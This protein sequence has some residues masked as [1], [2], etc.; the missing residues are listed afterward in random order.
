MEETRARI[1]AAAR[2]LLLSDEGLA[3]FTMDAMAR[4]AGVT[5]MTVYHQFE[6]KTAVYEAL[7]EDVAARGAVRERVTKALGQSD[8]VAALGDLI[9]AFVHFWLADHDLIRKVLALEEFD[10]ESRA[11]QRDTFRLQSI[12]MV[13]ERLRKAKKIRAQ[14]V[15]RNVDALYMLTGFWNVDA[16]A[17]AGRSER[18]ISERIKEVASLVFGVEI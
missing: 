11:G 3:A 16:L 1:I 13:M 4:R 18:Q 14:D 8:P 12:M 10:T 17:R 15:S 9:D 6:T 5:R 7:A 2:K